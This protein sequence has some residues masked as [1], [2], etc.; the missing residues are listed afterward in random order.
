M[1][2]HGRQRQFELSEFEVSL[3]YIMTS[4]LVRLHVRSCLDKELKISL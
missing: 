3:I 4:R 1:T 2:A